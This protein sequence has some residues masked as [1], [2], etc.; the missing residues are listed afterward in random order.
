MRAPG[1]HPIFSRQKARPPLTDTPD[2]HPGREA[3]VP[4]G[5]G[6]SGASNREKWEALRS[7]LAASPLAVISLTASGVVRGWNPAAEAIF[8]W[9]EGEALGRPLP[10]VPAERRTELLSLSERAW[11]GET[12]SGFQTRW[13]R[14]DTQ[15]VDLHLCLAAT[16]DAQGSATGYVLFASDVTA[17]K[18]LEEQFYRAQRMEAVGR[19]ASGVA[20][21]FNNLLTVISGFTAMALGNLPAESP[22][23]E[24]LE[25]V[26]KAA[27]TAAEL[28][29]QL[30]AFSRRQIQQ[31]EP[32]DLNERVRET[33]RMLRRLLGEDIQLRTRLGE[34]LRSIC[35]DPAR[36]DQVLLN[37]AVNARD[38]MPQGGI[39]E[40]ETGH[41]ELSEPRHLA[42]GPAPPGSYVVLRVTDTG[43]GMD[44]QVVAHLFEPFFTTKERGVGTG[45][46]L[47]TVYGIVRQSGGHI[48]V[49]S[50]SGEGTTFEILFPVWR[51]EPRR[52]PAKPAAPQAPPRGETVLLVEDD[53]GVR[54]L[55]R[56]VLQRAGYRVLAV[57]DPEQALAAAGSH[58][59]PIDLLLTDLV[60]PGMSG[61]RL[62]RLF[63]QRRPQAKVLY[64][65]GYLD[66]GAALEG[67]LEPGA[68]FLAKPFPPA[69]LLRAVR[70]ALG[71]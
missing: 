37:L 61:R 64:C 62:A 35:A 1:C 6:E 42:T 60:M 11:E 22:V 25:Q 15:P 50:A 31:P 29:N 16:R 57:S 66:E 27:Q 39:L 47:S 56:E 41:L 28:T 70:E 36:I 34:G 51:G 7:V 12:V 45:L 9:S 44:A 33:E 13:H 17:I 4:P 38:A 59:G 54:S 24:D 30:L 2:E 63:R 26:L 18:R 21:D 43:C 8:G 32:L 14:K 52:A 40:I 68:P 49:R 69:E 3:R 10:C 19:L 71:G 48:G 53:P 23:R 20:H 67:G 55:A 5:P 65:S 58:P 46:G